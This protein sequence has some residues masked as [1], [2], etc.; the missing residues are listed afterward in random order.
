M[1]SSPL[2]TCARADLPPQPSRPQELINAIH[3]FVIR[4]IER[5]VD[6]YLDAALLDH[7]PMDEFA[8]LSFEG[9]WSFLKNLTG[10]G[11]TT[12]KKA[13]ERIVPK[14]KDM[15]AASPARTD[16]AGGE[17][18]PA[19]GE[20]GRQRSQTSF[21][22]GGGGGGGSPRQE[23]AVPTGGRPAS[24]G[25]FSAV[26][27][28]FSSTSSLYLGGPSPPPGNPRRVSDEP[29]AAPPP[30]PGTEAVTPRTLTTFLTSALVILQLYE[31]NP[32]VICQALSQVVYWV[33]CEVFNRILTR[34]RY[35]CRSKAVQIRMNL[36]ALEDWLRDAGLPVRIATRHLEPVNQLLQ[37][38][39]TCSSLDDFDSLIVML[40]SLRSLNPLQM[41]RAVK[42]YR[43]ETGEGRMSDECAQYLAQLQKDWDKR[44][45]RIGV[46]TLQREVSEQERLR[47]DVYG[48]HDGPSLVPA[49]DRPYNP[50]LLEPA[51]AI[52]L[53]FDPDVPL[54]QYNPPSAPES[55]GELLDSRFML[56]FTL[57]QAD[58]LLAATPPKGAAFALLL[59]PGADGSAT[60]YLPSLPLA[61]PRPSSRSSFASLR[62]L[63]YA[64]RKHQPINE[65]PLEFLEW[66][67]EEERAKAPRERR[68]GSAL[69]SLRSGASI[70]VD[71]AAH[72]Q[73]RTPTDTRPS[74]GAGL[75]ADDTFRRGSSSR[76]DSTLVAGGGGGAGLS[77]PTADVDDFGS[78][79]GSAHN[80][81]DSEQ[82]ISSHGRDA[83]DATVKR[84][85]GRLASL[86][87]DDGGA[88]RPTTTVDRDDDD[89]D[90]ARTP[91]SSSKGGGQ[92]ASPSS[93]KGWFKSLPRRKG[94]LKA[95]INGGGST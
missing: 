2:P 82:T 24:V 6:G 19:S 44:R 84:K 95:L 71:P 61:S 89:D 67:D 83:S 66:L 29:P 5:R 41:R 79:R 90:D 37:W 34:R 32:A 23:T 39:Q 26:S 63:R 77:P 45:V 52:D 86:I 92:P 42:D 70:S 53:L 14:A 76:D 73:D 15:F 25:D 8:G 36:T 68:L 85:P 58:E 78:R 9:E 38:L 18:W 35:L 55:L 17:G 46:E 27:R 47:V 69:D 56:P 3:V 48:S 72:G 91:V 22:S 65:L 20:A 54:G 57:P 94:T 64:S 1:R 87:V 50:A 31:V 75:H 12:A 21:Q 59:P 10:R 49:E 30:P 4:F 11:A 60:Q 7:E 16:G 88:Y 62:P 80:R 33:G 74:N 43:F 28:S 13:A 51:T 81:G 40:S 93:A